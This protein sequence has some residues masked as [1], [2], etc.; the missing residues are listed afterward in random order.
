MIKERGNVEG[1]RQPKMI[2]MLREVK[3][4]KRKLQGIKMN[5]GQIRRR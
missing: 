2:K 4:G 3:R 1:K 5:R